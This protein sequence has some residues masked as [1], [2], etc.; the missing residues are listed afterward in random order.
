[1]PAAVCGR[2]SA[3]PHE[4]HRS[5]I[6][7]RPVDAAAKAAVDRS[8]AGCTREDKPLSSTRPVNVPHVAGREKQ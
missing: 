7:E 4:I 5:G 2:R 6:M 1:M 3:E 8:A